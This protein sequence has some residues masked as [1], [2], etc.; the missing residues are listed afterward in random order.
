M[1]I[2]LIEFITIGNKLIGIYI[3]NHKQ[4]MAIKQVYRVI[5]PSSM[6]LHV[7]TSN[8]GHFSKDKVTT[9]KIL[10]LLDII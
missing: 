8:G 10:F 7:N 6:Y 9:A 3:Y 5:P 2:K 4:S 1:I